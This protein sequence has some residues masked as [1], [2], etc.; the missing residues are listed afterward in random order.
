LGENE[1]WYALI[2]RLREQHRTLRALQDEL[3]RAEL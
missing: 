1:T 2:T 3:T